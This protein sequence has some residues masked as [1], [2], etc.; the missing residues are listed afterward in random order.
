MDAAAHQIVHQVIARRDAVEDACDEARLLVFGDA[1]EAEIGF[2]GS[3]AYLYPA[4]PSLQHSASVELPPNRKLQIMPELPEVETVVRGLARALHRQAPRRLDLARPD[5]RSAIPAGSRAPAR[6]PPDR[7]VFAPRQIHSHACRRRR[8]GDRA[9]RHV[10]PA[11]I[12]PPGEAPPRDKH[13]H[14][15]FRFEDGTELRFNDARRFGLLDYADRSERRRCIR[16]SAIS[17]RSRWATNSTV[18]RSPL[19]L[20]GKKTSIKA[21]LLDQ[22]VVAGLGNIYACEA[23]YGAAPLAAAP[24]RHG[25]RRSRR[26]PRDGDPRRAYARDRRRRQLAAR[27]RSGFRRAGLF[28]ASMGGLRQGRRALSRLRLPAPASGASCRA[29]ARLF[30]VPSASAEARLRAMRASLLPSFRLFVLC[31]VAAARPTSSLPA[32]RMCR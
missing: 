22:R 18:P 5:L 3:G 11:V 7:A 17:G 20:K 15:V 30:T 19:R 10:G 29:A 1:A 32:P 23:L 28:P 6:R 13:D 16:G 26:A 9:S 25:P 24:G 2:P 31:A 27:L 4:A 12:A 21:A 8:R 14:A